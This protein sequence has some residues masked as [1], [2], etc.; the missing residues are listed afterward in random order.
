MSC[1]VHESN[2][3]IFDFLEI[4]A[5]LQKCTESIDFEMIPALI[6]VTLLAIQFHRQNVRSVFGLKISSRGVG[7]KNSDRLNAIQAS[8]CVTKQI[9]TQTLLGIPLSDV[10]I[11]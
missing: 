7:D 3:V 8:W 11:R 9:E 10:T 5:F 4:K 1:H 2:C 6:R